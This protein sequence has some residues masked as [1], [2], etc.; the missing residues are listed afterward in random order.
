MTIYKEF[1]GHKY[2]L[3]GEY[4]NKH[5]ANSLAKAWKGTG[6]AWARIETT[7]QEGRP[8]YRVWICPKPKNMIRW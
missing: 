8:V 2:E 7:Q 5:E 1:G 6:S 4:T 3:R